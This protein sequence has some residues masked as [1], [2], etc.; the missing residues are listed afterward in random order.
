MT[1]TFGVQLYFDYQ[2]KKKTDPARIRTWNPL[3]R[4]QMHYPIGQKAS[5][6]FH[7]IMFLSTE[8]ML[9]RSVTKK[10]VA[11]CSFADSSQ[12]KFKN[13]FLNWLMHRNILRTIKTDLACTMNDSNIWSAVIFWLPEEKKNDPARIRTW[14]PL[15][16]SFST[17]NS[18]IHIKTCTKDEKNR[19][20]L[21][22]EW[23]QSLWCMY[24]LITKGKKKRPQQDSNLESPYSLW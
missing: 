3:I 7:I 8:L 10:G 15:G 13:S 19:P 9:T 5:H 18:Y 14:N 12:T 24:I 1:P 2:R 4:S 6:F 23:L 20:C 16:R 22:H 17:H 11:L 21:G